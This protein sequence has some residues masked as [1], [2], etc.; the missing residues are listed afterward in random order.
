MAEESISIQG[1][2]R[3]HMVP[4][5]NQGRTVALAFELPSGPPVAYGAPVQVLQQI[6]LRIPQVL[7]DA[8][9]LR[10]EAGLMDAPDA[11]AVTTVPWNVESVSLPAI[12][13]EGFVFAIQLDGCRL[14]LSFTLEQLLMLRQ[15]LA[16]I[17]KPKVAAKKTPKTAKKTEPKTETPKVALAKKAKPAA[18]SSLK[19]KKAGS[20]ERV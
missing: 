11:P 4:R 6:F 18:K 10:T 3:V 15:S 1:F 13:D 12:A 19:S 14:D 9:K 20:A 5:V 2:T 7:A 8:K 17:E 16:S